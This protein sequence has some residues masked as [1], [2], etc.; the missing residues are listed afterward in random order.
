MIR[1]C[2]AVALCLLGACQ[3]CDRQHECGS[4]SCVL[5]RGIAHCVIDAAPGDAPMQCD[6][7]TQAGCAAGEKCT[8][9]VDAHMPLYVGHIG[10]APDGTVSVGNPCIYG[11]PGVTGYDA[12]VAGAVCSAYRNNDV[13]LCKQVCDPLAGDLACDE[14][15]HNCVLYPDLFG[16]STMPP[17]VGI[18]EPAC[19]ALADNDFDGTG[20]AST[21]SAAHCGS[22][23]TV[24]CYGEPSYGSGWG[25]RWSCMPERHPSVPGLIGLRHRVQC[26][27]ANGCDGP[28]PYINS[29]N[30]G[31]EPLLYETTTS[32]TAICVAICK[33]KNCYAGNCGTNADNR[34]GEAP[35]RCTTPDR[36]GTFDTSQ[37][38]EH[39][40][41]S[42]AFE[43]D[44][45]G[46]FL[47]SPTSDTVGFCVDHSKYLYD[48][49]G[50]TVP[51]TPYPPCT[52]LPDGFGS[53]S[54][55]GAGDLGCVDSTHVQFATGKQPPLGDLRLLA[56]P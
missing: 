30:Q 28:S 15:E 25:T 48:S 7:L 36:V 6:L 31:Y 33:P 11:F 21:K 51:D 8:W 27:P 5:N 42:W 26:T 44:I 22:D 39:C 1:Y 10:C 18:C 38:G 40:V 16:G 35:H 14:P 20:S 53:G 52:T 32:T 24:G 46:N 4:C 55:L 50:D 17:T 19:D 9:I 34:L 29:C 43:I 2:F 12:C 13:G 41:Y 45:V 47:R 3:S 37:G 23:A 49:D 56:R 54:A